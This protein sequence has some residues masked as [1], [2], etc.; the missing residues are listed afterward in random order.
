M[1]HTRLYNDICSGETLY[2]AFAYALYDRN[3]TDSY[4]DLFELDYVRNNR[5]QIL[6][7]L[8]SE[9]ETPE[10]YHQRNAYAY[11]YPKTNL[12]LRR[13][14]HLNFK[15][16]VVRYAFAIVL[17]HSL[18]R[19]MKDTCFAYRRQKGQRAARRLLTHFADTD[20]PNWVGWQK[21]Q[22][23]NNLVLLRTDI[24]SFYD[25]ISHDYF[26]C[27]L[28]K[29]LAIS[30]QTPVVKLFKKVL[31]VPVLSYSRTGE[32][33]AVDPLRQG[34]PIGN[35]TEGFF[36]NIYL[37][38]IDEAMSQLPHVQFGRYADDMRI[39]GPGRA[40]VL[41]ALNELQKLL[42]TKGLNLNSS[43]TQ[44][45]ESKEEVAD[46]RSKETDIFAYWGEDDELQA[47]ENDETDKKAIEGFVDPPL[48]HLSRSFDEVAKLAQPEETRGRKTFLPIPDPRK[49]DWP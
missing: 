33:P 2:Q 37:M 29:R 12:C 31:S 17:A 8:A 34:L 1:D 32:S 10:K 21:E 18:D 45:A 36:A 43:K 47:Q 15:D 13:M 49:R 48:G 30:T 42:L 16:L 44:L 27:T 3:K 38:D 19:F 35:N 23:Q 20:Y 22:V 39:F 28:T 7:E 26:V 6:K 25:S 24:S 11:F 5:E 4:A 40:E 46:L 9:L 41:D 14:I